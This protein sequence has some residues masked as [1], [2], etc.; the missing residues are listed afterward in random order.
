MMCA[1]K[2]TL[3]QEIPD[4]LKTY[5][6]EQDASL[7]TP[8]DHASWRFILKIAKSFFSKHAHQKYLDGLCETGI[9]EERIPLIEE[10]DE[11]LSKFGWRAVAVSGFIP[12]AAFM[13]YLSLGIL[14]IACDMRKIEHLSYTPAPDIVHEAAG[15]A[16]IIADPAYAEY[17][18]C[19]GE[20]SRKAIMSSQDLNV[21][22]AIRNLSEIKEDPKSQPR[23]IQA[24]QKQLDQALASVDYVSEATQL[25]RMGWWTF[26]YGLVGPMNNPKIYGAGLLSSVSESYHCLDP[27][28]KKIPFSVDCIRTNFDITKPQP[29]LFVA[30]SF[31]ALVQGL[32]D[33]ENQMAYKQG[34]IVGLEKAQRSAL[35]NTTVYDSGIQ[36]SGCL[37]SFSLDEKKRPAYLKFQGPVQL[38]YQ[39]QEIEGQGVSQHKEG[40]GSPIGKVL[41]FEKPASEL[42]LE[43]LRSLGFKD[44]QKGRMEFESGVTVEGVL[45]NIFQK[46]G[47][48][49][50]LTFQ[51]CTVSQKDQILFQPEWGVYDMACGAQIISVFG[52]AADRKK[53]LNAVGGFTQKPRSQK[54]N[55]TQENQDLCKL[56]AQVREMREKKKPIDTKMTEIVAELERKYPQDWLLRYELIELDQTHQLHSSWIPELKK[57]LNQIA[58]TSKDLSELIKRG[59]E[60]L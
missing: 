44:T 6:V 54:S 29:Q 48:N 1:K 46:E 43:D 32:H 2:Q 59:L 28:V 49:L 9:S 55:L 3:T 11:C 19:Y 41:K 51:N 15:H 23:D 56:Y 25:S 24:A 45:K 27:H 34:G 31:E 53:Y 58:Q 37:S 42:S 18:R 7:Y 26:E 20:I 47:K 13:E 4:Y 52:G 10:M 35:V 5:I 21:Y 17:L 33:L 36:V 39:D 38:S 8:M 16:P 14:P 12:P 57:N 30:S 40:F 50:V 22:E 60:V